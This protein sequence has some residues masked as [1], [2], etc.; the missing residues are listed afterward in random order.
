M[1][2][3]PPSAIVTFVNHEPPVPAKERLA[4]FLSAHPGA[5]DDYSL[6]AIA[7]ELGVSRERVR[8]LRPGWHTGR[9]PETPTARALKMFLAAHPEAVMSPALGGMTM[10]AVAQS[11]DRNAHV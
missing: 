7:R 2:N 9:R 5:E 8:Q 3:E 10:K 6:S 11:I 4:Q 1:T